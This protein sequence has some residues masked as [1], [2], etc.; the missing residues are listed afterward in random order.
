MKRYGLLACVAALVTGVALLVVPGGVYSAHAQAACESPF[1]DQVV[2][3]ET[4]QWQLTDFCQHSIP[5]EQITGVLRQRDTI[6]PIDNP[7]FE[8]LEAASAWLQPQSPVLSIELNGEARAYPLAILTWHEIVND[9]VGGVPVA[10]TFCPLCNSAFAFDRR[11]GDAVLRFGV[12]GNLRNSNLLM[13]DDQTES[14]WQQFTGDAVVGTYTGTQLT[15]YPAIITG[16]GAFAAQY[17]QGQV[18]TRETGAAR[19]YGENP[20]AF[21]DENDSPFLFRG[22]LDDRLPPTE[23]VLSGFVGGLGVAYPF[24]V[25]RDARVI[26]DTVGGV[27]VV[28][29]WQGGAATA[30]GN[31]VIDEAQDIGWATLFSRTVDER[32]L[33]FAIREDA[34]IVDEETNSEWNA[35]GSATAGELAGTQ[36]EPQVAAPHFWFSWAAFEVDTLVYGTDE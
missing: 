29:F 31:P 19:P 3:F 13:W 22:T 36:L 26:N 14:W 28:A 17:P 32:V 20:Y 34:V 23:Y 12:T 21:Y 2:T 24:S 15:L 35:F 7:Q 16:F 8:T 6:P 25:L 4:S 5:Y 33:T 30:L 27:P 18:L 10:I 9:T 11:V 1:A